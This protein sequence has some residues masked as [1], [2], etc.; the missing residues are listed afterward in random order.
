MRN[1]SVWFYFK[2]YSLIKG[3][4]YLTWMLRGFR[5]QFCRRPCRELRF[6]HYKGM[7]SDCYHSPIRPGEMHLI[8]WD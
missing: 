8:D 7:C 1:W 3:Y 2:K 4:N 6:P 5:C